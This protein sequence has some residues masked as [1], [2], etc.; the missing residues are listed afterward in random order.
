MASLASKLNKEFYTDVTKLKLLTPNSTPTKFKFLKS[1]FND[2]DEEEG[3]AATP[4][5]LVVTGQI[6][7]SSE[8]FKQ[9][10]YIIE[11][12]L[13]PTY[14]FEPPDVR[15]ATPIYHPNVDKDGKRKNEKIEFVIYQD[16]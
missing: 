11:M 8:V 4:K 1:P 12:K 13:T 16:F 10:S 2:D 3:A 14:P 9:G 15:F 6:F 7:P 5:E